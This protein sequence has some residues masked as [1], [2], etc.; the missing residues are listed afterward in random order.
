MTVKEI[1]ELVREDLVKVEQE[2]PVADDRRFA[3]GDF[4]FSSDGRRVAA[5]T[6]RDRAIVEVWDVALGQSLAR[7]RGSG[8]PVTAVAFG[9]D[10]Q[11]L[12][13]AAACGPKGRPVVTL[14]DVASGRA[15]RTF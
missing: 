8:G 4:A 9:P 2:L 7:L 11:S 13:T 12:A 10:G 1:F 14:W 3:R 15:I 6:R 5:P